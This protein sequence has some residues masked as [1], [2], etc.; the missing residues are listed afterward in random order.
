MTKIKLYT[1]QACQLS[2]FCCKTQGFFFWFSNMYI[3]FIACINFYFL[4]NLKVF[5]CWR[6][7]GLRL[8]V[9]ISVISNLQTMLYHPDLALYNL[10]QLPL[11]HQYVVIILIF[12]VNLANFCHIV[13]V[14]RNLIL[15]FFHES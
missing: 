3:H 2:R 1:G 10:L 4:V 7:A 15:Y 13:V 8:Q 11:L 6:L 5:Q 9:A 14:C 12:Q